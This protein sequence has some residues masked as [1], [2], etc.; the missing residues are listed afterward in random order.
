MLG[1]PAIA[2]V[3]RDHED[4]VPRSRGSRLAANDWMYVLREIRVFADCE[5]GDLSPERVAPEPLAHE[6]SQE[7][8]H[9]P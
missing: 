1:A 6:S 4:R 5:L 9:A 7:G 2:A 3:G 8:T